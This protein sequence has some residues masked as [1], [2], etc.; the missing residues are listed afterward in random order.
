MMVGSHAK[1]SAGNED[2]LAGLHIIRQP[3]AV[4]QIRAQHG[5]NSDTRIPPD[6]KAKTLAEL[7][8]GALPGTLDALSGPLF[9]GALR[10]GRR[11]IASTSLSHR[12]HAFEHATNFCRVRSAIRRALSID[13]AKVEKGI[14]RLGCCDVQFVPVRG[15]SG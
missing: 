1:G 11:F 10:R 3:L 13:N 4:I 14:G 9:F 6:A 15:R 2:H 12:A 7:D 8:D 5:G